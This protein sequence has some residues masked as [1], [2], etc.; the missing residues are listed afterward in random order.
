MVPS[1]YAVFHERSQSLRSRT[2]TAR[3]PS[4]TPVSSRPLRPFRDFQRSIS[5]PAKNVSAVSK[6]RTPAESSPPPSRNS[7]LMTSI[8]SR[9]HRWGTRR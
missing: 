4:T 5:Q 2:S 1:K 8:A 3:Y 6:S 9:F 7:T